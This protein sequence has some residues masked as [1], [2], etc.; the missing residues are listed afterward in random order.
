[1]RPGSCRARAGQQGRW[2]RALQDT[3]PGHSVL[4][5]GRM[6]RE[7]PRGRLESV[8][9]TEDDAY[10]KAFAVFPL[11]LARRLGPWLLLGPD[12]PFCTPEA[13]WHPG[14]LCTVPPGPPPENITGRSE[15]AGGQGSPRRST[16]FSAQSSQPRAP[17]SPGP[18]PQ[19]TRLIS[20]PA[21][22]QVTSTDRAVSP[23]PGWPAGP[24]WHPGDLGV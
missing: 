24:R 2:P 23:Q 17:P 16:E 6:R 18:S 10:R 1:M 13:P 15:S 7:T 19:P 21:R 20:P 4:A 5:A 3:G 11:I 12:S 22:P 14:G 8:L 9:P